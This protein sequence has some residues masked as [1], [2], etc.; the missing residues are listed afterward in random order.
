MISVKTILHVIAIGITNFLS[1]FVFG[2][3]IPLKLNVRY[4][5]LQAVYSTHTSFILL[6]NHTSRWDPFILSFPVLRPIRWVGSDAVFRNSARILMMMCG[7]IPKIKE[8]SDMIAIQSMKK[9]VSLGHIVGMFPEGNQTWNGETIDIIPATAKLVRLLKIPVIV[10]L[11]KGGYLTNPRWAWTVR[12]SRIDVHYRRVIDAD[13]VKTLKLV[14]IERRINDALSYDEYKWQKKQ[15]VPIRS[16]IRAEYMELAHFICPACETVG[17]MQ[18]QGNQL[19]C[20]CGYVVLVDK[21]GFFVYPENGP[22]FEKPSHWMRWQSRFLV[23]RIREKLDEMR[24]GGN[25]DVV[26]LRDADVTLM[27][28][29]RAL[30]MKTVLRGEARLYKN[31]LEIGNPG[32]TV[33][34]F[35]L[36]ETTAVN[37]FK[38]Q[39]FEFRFEKT[40]YRLQFPT[41]HVSGLK[42]EIAYKGLREIQVERGEWAGNSE[43]SG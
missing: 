10:P 32:E 4:K 17:N 6:P 8:Q 2:I 28:G 18:S 3:I 25:V 24:N 1:K 15:R 43:N 33:S 29:K 30:P 5:N 31:R 38:Q 14:E 11:L 9:A 42:W 39:K 23:D 20:T 21:Y 27:M 13:E 12:R 35:P 40:Q 22:S 16:S 37:I 41:R 26:L 34:V 19:F 7:A 36:R